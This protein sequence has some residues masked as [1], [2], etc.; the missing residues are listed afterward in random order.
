MIGLDA[1]EAN[2][3]GLPLPL[4]ERAGVR[5]ANSRYGGGTPPPGGGGGGVGG[6]QF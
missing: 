5:G 2:S 1:P 4:G 6:R 3:V